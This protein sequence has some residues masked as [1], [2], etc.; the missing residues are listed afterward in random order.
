ML[1]VTFLALVRWDV[2]I[3]VAKAMPLARLIAERLADG[4]PAV[5][6]QSRCCFVA[7]ERRCNEEEALKPF[8]TSMRK[9]LDAKTLTSLGE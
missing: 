2:E 9:M 4:S 5:R 7:F 6:A 8:S 3:I 1:K